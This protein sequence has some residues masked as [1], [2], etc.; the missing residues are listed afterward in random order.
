[1]NAI[2][3]TPVVDPDDIRSEE[4]LYEVIQGQRVELPP[5]SVLSVW[6]AS[7]LQSLLGSYADQHGLG[8]VVTEGLFVFDSE[9]DERRR[10]DTA[11]G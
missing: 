3:E 7:R 4:S 6:I 8:T 10:P 11:A 2:L 5:M 1:M 9:H